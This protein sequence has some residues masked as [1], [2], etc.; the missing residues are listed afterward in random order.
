MEVTDTFVF[1]TG[2]KGGEISIKIEVATIVAKKVTLLVSVQSPKKIR[3]LSDELG[4][5][6]KT[7]TNDIIDL[8]KEN[9]EILKFSKDF[10]KTYEKLLQEK[11][12]LEKEHSKLFSKVNQLELE[13]KKL[14]KS[15]EVVEP[16]KKFDVL[17][18]EVDSLKC[19]ISRLQD[20]ALNFSKFKKSSVVLD[21]MLSRQ[22][23]SRDKE[24]LGFSNNE[25]TN[26]VC[27]KCDLLPNDWIVDSGC[28]K[29]MTGNKRLFTSYK[30]YDGKHVVFGSNLK[31]KVIGGGNI[32]HDCIIITNVEHV[33]GLA[34]NL[35]NVVEYGVSSSLSNT[36]YSSQLINMAYPL[37]L[38]TAYRSSRTEAEIFNFHAKF[39]SIFRTNPT[40]DLSLVLEYSE[41][42]EAEAMAGTM[43][44]YMSKTRTD[45]G[46]GV[47][48][49]KI[50][51]KDQ[52]EL[53]GQFLKEL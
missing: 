22:K 15:K 50:D 43:E 41:E 35:S 32:S 23:L 48:R 17:T 45:Y 25:K 9:E 21:D 10:S 29:H 8:Q 36:A 2:N 37:P 46:S 39:F 34:F 13:V 18:Q 44:Q 30:A 51:N 40:D 53:K 6:A 28:T 20:E 38:V 11:C 7:A 16:C 47:T 42:E 26:S 52:F 5:I 33:S 31:D 3:L 27:L 49:P 24:G 1:L 19:N 14:A 12:A 4:A